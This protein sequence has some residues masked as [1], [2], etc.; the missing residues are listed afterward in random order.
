[1]ITTWVATEIMDAALTP[2]LLHRVDDCNRLGR[3]DKR[4]KLPGVKEVIDI[5]GDRLPRR[6]I[7]DLGKQLGLSWL[8]PLVQLRRY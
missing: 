7:D 8:I 4:R 2:V 6:L 1:M 3:Q 5:A